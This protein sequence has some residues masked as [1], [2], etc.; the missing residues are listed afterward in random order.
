[1]TTTPTLERIAKG[2]IRVS[3]ERDRTKR[4]YHQHDVFGR[5]R[6]GGLI[7]PHHVR[8]AEKYAKHYEGAQGFD[9]RASDQPGDHHP[10]YDDPRTY[11]A[12][13]LAHANA[14]L[15]DVQGWMLEQLITDST[16]RLEHLGR[17]VSGYT[18]R[19]Q[20]TAYATAVVH[21]GLEALAKHWGLA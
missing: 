1:M 12:Q 10:D 18:E 16:A 8:A 13:M 19:R 7:E 2:D 20:C 5:L 6:D 17:R 3:S 15:S 9:V 11:H 14:K 4:T 21:E